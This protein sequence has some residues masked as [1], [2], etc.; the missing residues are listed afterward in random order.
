MVAQISYV[1]SRNGW[2]CCHIYIN[3]T[4]YYV[5]STVLL[6]VV[7]VWVPLSWTVHWDIEAVSLPCVSLWSFFLPAQLM[8]AYVFFLLPLPRFTC[9]LSFRSG[10]KSCLCPHPIASTQPKAAHGAYVTCIPSLAGFV[11]MNCMQ[12]KQVRASTNSWL[13]ANNYALQKIFISC[14]RIWLLLTTIQV[15]TKCITCAGHCNSWSCH[16]ILWDDHIISLIL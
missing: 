9:V 12:Y 16:N 15:T 14:T 6:H 8:S 3:M 10:N 2:N 1:I 5:S 7:S 4:F 13:S 11:K